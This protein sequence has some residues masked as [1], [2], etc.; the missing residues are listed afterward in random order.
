M[1]LT[2]ALIVALGL[3]ALAHS[4]AEAKP[5]K[6]K[7]PAANACHL[8]TDAIADK[9]FMLD[10]NRDYVIGGGYQ[11]NYCFY[12]YEQPGDVS[13]QR[14]GYLGL[15]QWRL[16]GNARQT[17][18][19]I[20]GAQGMQAVKI[21]GTNRACGIESEHGMTCDPQCQ[22]LTVI[23]FRRGVTTGKLELGAPDWWAS[24]GMTL[25]DATALARKVIARWP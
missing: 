11:S 4:A 22:A 23:D 21:K 3:A 7:P 15:T 24:F 12:T 25:G 10:M 1:R 17:I 9:F 13:V 16:I 5:P 19:S 2:T 14:S 8:F 6:A 18:N 20:C